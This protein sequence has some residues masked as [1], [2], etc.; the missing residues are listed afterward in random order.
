MKRYLSSLSV[1]IGLFLSSA[2]HAD[3]FKNDEIIPLS[4]VIGTSYIPAATKPDV[5]FK[6][7][8]SLQMELLYRI[9]SKLGAGAGV[10][11]FDRGF[12]SSDD[13]RQYNVTVISDRSRFADV[14][15]KEQLEA[16]TPRAKE[17]VSIWS[18]VMNKESAS[19]FRTLFAILT[20]FSILFLLILGWLAWKF[21]PLIR[22]RG[23]K[24]LFR[25]L[26]I[27]EEKKEET[28]KTEETPTEV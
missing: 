1:L 15:L 3:E 21:Y 11:F 4:F 26:P 9:T 12:E 19:R 7:S 10:N 13:V 16:V 27:Q 14:A 22:K 5:S 6:T 2:I 20:I 25:P 8:Y 18:I 17:Y 28:T 24:E 23:F